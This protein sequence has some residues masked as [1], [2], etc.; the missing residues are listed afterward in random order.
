MPS[1]IQRTWITCILHKEKSFKLR[2]F[3]KRNLYANSNVLE[4]NI[5]SILLKLTDF[6]GVFV[7]YVKNVHLVIDVDPNVNLL[8]KIFNNNINY[9]TL[10]ISNQKDKFRK[11]KKWRMNQQTSKERCYKYIWV[12]LLTKRWFLKMYILIKK[13]IITFYH[14]KS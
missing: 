9:W 3:S 14:T 11:T 5:L 6:V 8:I 1:L 4:I 7:L 12:K 2:L 10:T 13:T